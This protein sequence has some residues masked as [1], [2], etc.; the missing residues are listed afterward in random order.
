MT[1]PTPER[2]PL[3]GRVVAI[4]GRM[5][6]LVREEAIAL[7][8]RLGGT[9]E[10]TPGAATDYLVVG[11]IGWPLK[12]DGRLTHHLETAHRLHAEGATIEV[13][14]ETEFLTLIGER[15]V[16]KDLGR[17]YTAQ[18][19]S[20]ILGVKA[21]AVSE[22]VRRGLLRPAKVVNTLRYFDFGQVASARA[23]ARL[24]GSGV[25][26]ARI[27]TSLKQVSHWWPSAARTLAQLESLGK[28]GRLY[29]RLDDG[30]LAE[31]SGQL[32][33]D[34]DDATPAPPERSQNVQSLA[35]G[36]FGTGGCEPQTPEA[37]FEAALRFEETDRPALAARAYQEALLAGGPKPQTTFNL[38]NVLFRMGR[39]AEAAQRFLQTVELDPDH[40]HAWNNLG[41]ALGDLSHLGDAVP[42]FR[43]ALGIN[44]DYPDAHYNLA[45]TL[46]LLK[47]LA[48][49]R[50][51]WMRYMDLDPASP[52]ADHVRERLLATE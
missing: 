1:E 15:V 3:E 14:S 51:H 20:R 48:S 45:E 52:W 28:D 16:G 49:A 37:W 40:A 41:N 26:S 42:A 50:R 46:Y 7:I 8:E 35:G 22:W 43:R 29:V 32:T 4:T 34:F 47:D 19:L 24:L 2:D 18:E 21:G 39:K 5:A 11:E 12:A 27:R 23:L 25:S 36:A 30:V 9:Y 31:P 33:F 38:G 17:L 13:I 44:P 10:P 6:S